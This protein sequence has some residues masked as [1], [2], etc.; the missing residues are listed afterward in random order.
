MFLTPY[1]LFC[2]NHTLT[3]SVLWQP[4]PLH[5]GLHLLGLFFNRSS[6]FTAKPGIAIFQLLSASFRSIMLRHAPVCASYWCAS[7]ALAA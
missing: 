6:G 4:H 5:A 1:L 7:L 2:T 3:A